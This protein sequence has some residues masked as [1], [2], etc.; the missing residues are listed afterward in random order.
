MNKLKAWLIRKLGGYVLSDI[1]PKFVYKT[2]P[3]I[4]IRVDILMPEPRMFHDNEA[5]GMDIIE[6]EAARK[7]GEFIIK[8]HLYTAQQTV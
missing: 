6:R 2:L 4:K 3:G 5:L 7:L 1:A 8:N